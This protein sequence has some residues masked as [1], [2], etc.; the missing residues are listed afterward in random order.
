MVLLKN[1]D[2]TLPLSADV[3]SI[4][5]IGPLA[6]SKAVMVGSWAGAGHADRDTRPVSLLTGIKE[7]AGEQVKIHYAKGASYAFQDADDVSG[8]DEAIRA[9]EKS[10]VIILAMGEEWS[11]T[12]EAASR[13][14]LDMPG[15]QIAL[16]KALRK[17]NKPIILVLLSGRPLTID[18]EQ[19]NLDSIL[20]AW[21]PGTMGG[22]A[23]AD[24][25]FGDYNPSGKLPVTFPRTVGQVPIYYNMNNTGR[26]YDPRQPNSKYV[27]RYLNT[28]NSPL[29]PFGFG[30][31]YT[32]F[33]YSEIT[34]SKTRIIENDKLTASINLTNSGNYDGEEVV[35]LYVRDRVGS[36]LVQ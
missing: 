5:L 21:Y 23:I 2:K 31:S 19:E 8:F 10:E 20:M 26:P 4:A 32:T 24:V 29:Y 30:L 33:D 12:G 22:L 1:N 15:N 11:M 16:M 3:K 6:N 27:S 28:D 35:Q 18:W 25:L 7:R 36:L 13:T 17:L 9:A 14:K 34:L